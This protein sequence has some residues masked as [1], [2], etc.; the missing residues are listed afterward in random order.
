MINTNEKTTESLI[1]QLDWDTVEARAS[2]L[3]AQH[4]RQGSGPQVITK[5]DSLH[6]WVMV[7]TIEEILNSSEERSLNYVS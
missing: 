2:R 1:K 7:A 3:L 5:E 4:L 6:Y